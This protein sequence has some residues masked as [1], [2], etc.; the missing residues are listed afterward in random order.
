MSTT[1][2]SGATFAAYL[3]EKRHVIEAYIETHAPAPLSEELTAPDL[4][5]YLYTPLARFTASG[6]KRTRPALCL[7]GCEAVG[8]TDALALSSAAAI[9][10]FQSAALIHDDI[11]DEGELRRGKPCVY[12]SEG[13][14]IAINVGDLALVAVTAKIL[15]DETLEP[16]VRM[17]VLEGLVS[18]EERTLEG[19]A[20]DL[21]WVRDGRWDISTRDYLRMAS[22]KT[23][24]Y[25]LRSHATLRGRHLRRRNRRADRG[26]RLLWHGRRTGLPAP[27]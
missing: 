5:R 9:E 8:G 1:S 27:G 26:A 2:N 19:Q 23:A 13:T 25:L 22:H 4:D 14:G 10:D 20:L 24:F 7:L 11:A 17:R 16:A 18:M 12:L 21:G 15:R 3:A 6:G